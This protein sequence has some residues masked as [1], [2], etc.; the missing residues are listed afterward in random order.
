MKEQ[1]IINLGFKKEYGENESFYYYTLDIG[2]DSPLTLISPANDEV[3]DDN[4]WYVTIF[5]HQSIKFKERD[6]LRDFIYLLNN[7]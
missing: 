5:N 7:L 1:D 4:W 3:S 2:S 6:Q